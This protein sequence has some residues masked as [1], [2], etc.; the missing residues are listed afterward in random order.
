MLLIPGVGDGGGIAVGTNPDGG[1]GRAGI[2]ERPTAERRS[3]ESFDFEGL[4]PA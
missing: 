1:A 2:H 3:G 4:R